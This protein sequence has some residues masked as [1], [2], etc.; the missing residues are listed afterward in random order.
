MN[1]SQAAKEIKNRVDIVEVISQYL[2]LRKAGANYKVL[3]PF[4]KEKTASFIVSPQKQIFKCFGCGIGGNV[5]T[6]LQKIE[7]ISFKEAV[8]ILAKTLGIEIKDEPL[9]KIEVLFKINQEAS[10][11]YQ[12][13]LFKAENDFA[14]KYLLERGLNLEVIK[15]FRLGYAPFNFSLF[16]FLRQK[17]YKE[18]D[19]HEAGLATQSKDFFKE[20]L[21]F[22]IFDMR[23]RVI[24]F[25]GRIVNDDETKPKYI[26]TPQT[27][28]YNKGKNLYCL[29]F[30][31]DSIIKEGRA[32]V[33]E[34]YFDAIVL[35]MHGFY[36]VV[37]TL[38]TALTEDQVGILKRY[39]SSIML[40]FDPD[41]AGKK[42]T[43]RGLNILIEQELE[44]KIVPLPNNYDPASFLQAKGKE[45]F[46]NLLSQ[47]Q[48]LTIFRLNE[49]LAIYDKSSA[50]GKLCIIKD[51][52]DV[53]KSMRSPIKQH[54]F[55]SRIA[56]AINEKEEH[57]ALEIKSLL[58]REKVIKSKI[59]EKQAFSL[60]EEFLLKIILEN[61]EIKEVLINC[62][63]QEDFEDKDMK[64]IF[65]IVRDNPSLEI[66]ELINLLSERA[67]NV[68]AKLA[69][70]KIQVE[71]SEK[72]LKQKLLNLKL[73]RLKR[74]RKQINEKIKEKTLNSDTIVSLQKKFLES[75]RLEGRL[76][77]L[78]IESLNLQELTSKLKELERI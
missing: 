42:A 14:L 73:K 15:K 43:I 69:I 61:K 20:R 71:F 4:H 66:A 62:I 22:P 9:P 26:N 49:A 18:E 29:N 46:S 57:I 72:I 6:F 19:I 54:E 74:E 39:A 13:L 32:L 21:I 12:D 68:L 1:L 63:N 36:N 51:L 45:R 5:F 16:N 2:P 41:E 37:G 10:F 70:E 33:V 59:I 3:C 55:I 65:S 60:D 52:L 35:Y 24:G 64:E 30:A 38:G 25:G 53:I 27:L 11:I 8:F 17:G 31:K 23:D 7:D 56:D 75:K 78:D 34:G 77:G 28:V 48:E 40:I 67:R 44:P 58:K 47:A 50:K 76:K